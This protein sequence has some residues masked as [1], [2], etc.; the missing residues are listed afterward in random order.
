MRRFRVL[1]CCAHNTR[2]LAGRRTPADLVWSPYATI[3][4]P[5]ESSFIHHS[6]R[7][8]ETFVYD[9]VLRCLRGRAR[10]DTVTS[11]GDT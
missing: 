2:R 10:G 8:A 1:A 9:V 3:T 6:L 5:D 4:R 7:P 11:R